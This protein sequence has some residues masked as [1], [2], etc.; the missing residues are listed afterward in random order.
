MEIWR[1]EGEIWSGGLWFCSRCDR[2]ITVIVCESGV[3]RISVLELSLE[4]VACRLV[5]LSGVN[6]CVSPGCDSLSFKFGFNPFSTKSR[7][8]IL[9]FRNQ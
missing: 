1:K 3:G 7:P 5:G 9:R 6:F 8:I 4:K 2:S